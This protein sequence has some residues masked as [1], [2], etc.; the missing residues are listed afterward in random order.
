MPQPPKFICWH[1]G[2]WSRI[3]AN[4]PAETLTIDEVLDTVSGFRTVAESDSRTVAADDDVSPSWGW[5]GQ[6][7]DGFL[8]VEGADGRLRALDATDLAL[9]AMGR[10][11]GTVGAL[12]TLAAHAVSPAEPE[13]PTLRAELTERVAFLVEAALLQSEA[14]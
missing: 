12:V 9:I 6:L 2:L 5:M 10:T 13:D 8:H 7:A 4:H 11:A 1:Q 3:D 14:R